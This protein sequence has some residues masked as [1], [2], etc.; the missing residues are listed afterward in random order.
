MRTVPRRMR[1]RLNALSSYIYLAMVVSE[2]FNVGSSICLMYAEDHILCH[3][4]NFRVT[5]SYVLTAAS[6]VASCSWFLVQTADYVISG[7]F[8]TVIFNNKFP[9]EN[10]HRI[11]LH[12][13]SSDSIP[14]LP[15][16]LSINLKF[17]LKNPHHKLPVH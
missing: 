9:P 3:S 8:L 4:M 17:C 7:D 15:L 2:S 6:I 16:N 5:A 1:R 12:G 10:T 13:I 14:N 11:C